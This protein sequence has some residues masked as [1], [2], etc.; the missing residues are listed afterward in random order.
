MPHQPCVDNHWVMKI[1]CMNYHP[2]PG[3]S[4]KGM[5]QANDTLSLF[6]M[7]SFPY[8]ETSYPERLWPIVHCDL[9]LNDMSQGHETLLGHVQ[10]FCEILTRSKMAVRMNGPDSD[11]CN[12]YFTLTLEVRP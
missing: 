2:N 6:I 11:F 10:Q 4:W 9:D 3:H 12:V 1:S 7:W 8:I 5:T